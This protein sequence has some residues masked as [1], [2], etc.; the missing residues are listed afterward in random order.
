MA[1][2]VLLLSRPGHPP[3][4]PVRLAGASFFPRSPERGSAPW[5]SYQQKWC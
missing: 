5:L 3:L 2:Q 1:D 4:L